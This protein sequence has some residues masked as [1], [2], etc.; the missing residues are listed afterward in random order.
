M[1]NYSTLS[2]IEEGPIARVTLTRGDILNR[3]DDVATEEIA[4]VIARFARPGQIRAL[5]LASTGRAF[6]AGGDLAE[7]R[8]L[9]SDPDRRRAAWDNGR[10]IIYGMTEIP[11]PVIV[12]LHG[13][14]YGLA[15]SIVLSADILV[16]SR[17]SRIGDPHVKVGLAAGD[18]GC[19]VWP[20]S[21]GMMR[22]K[23]HLLTGDPISAEDAFR[24]GAVT[25]LVETPEEVLPLA[26]QIASRVAGLAP[27]AVQ[28]TKR[29]LNHVMHRQALDVFE[30]SMALEQYGIWSEDL[31]EAVDAFQEKRPPTYH[32][33]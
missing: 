29:A 32:N 15:T 19:L 8:R 2:L 22:A 9:M 31:K 17:N 6:S 14:V 21:M 5:I 26:E 23:R 18:G 1:A 27:M 4:D 3:M 24:L 20:A 16:A 30:F 7:I 12:A 10:K 25:D 11:I 33:R 13:D 28:L